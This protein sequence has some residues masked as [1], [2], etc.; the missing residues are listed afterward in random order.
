MICLASIA[1]ETNTLAL[2]FSALS[3]VITAYLSL[4]AM[5]RSHFRRIIVGLETM[6]VLIVMLVLAALNQPE[7]LQQ[8]VPEEKPTIAVLWDDSA[9]METKD[10]PSGNADGTMLSRRESIADLTSNE[11][12]KA[13]SEKFKVVVEPFSSSLDG[14]SKGTNIGQALE[15]A[16]NRHKNL[17]A[18]VL[19][20]DGIWN[21]GKPPTDVAAVYRLDKAPIY[22]LCA[23]S[24]VA[25]PDLE[26]ASLD[27]P[28]FAVVGKPTRIPY[29]IRSTLP[30]PD[31]STSGPCPARMARSW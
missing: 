3:L 2:L 11:P 26:V 28:T 7:Q 16:A 23:G 9:S 24:K 17:L 13:Y 4:T 22:T 10:V 31:H 14:T 27:A 19:I 29:T 12:W 6:R 8:F 1:F 5:R 15:D 25:L 21:R 20:S 30:Q 18:A